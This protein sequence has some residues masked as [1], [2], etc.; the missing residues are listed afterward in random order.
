M[1]AD[2]W[3]CFASWQHSTSYRSSDHWNDS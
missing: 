3:S 1:N 2:K